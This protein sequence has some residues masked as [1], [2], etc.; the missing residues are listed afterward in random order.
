MAQ[1]QLQ[2]GLSLPLGSQGVAALPQLP[3]VFE[4]LELPGNALD[5][6]AA[7][8]SYLKREDFPACDFRDLIAARLSREITGESRAIVTEYKDQLRRMLKQAGEF[9]AQA[10]G[11]DPDWEKLCADPAATAVWN[12]ILRATAGDRMAAGIRLR[13]PVRVPGTAGRAAREAADWLLRLAGSQLSL[14]L[15]V[16]PHELLRQQTDWFDMLAP[17]RFAVDAV[18]FCYESELGNQLLY[19]HIQPFLAALRRW[20]REIIVYLAPSGRADLE[21]LAEVVQAAEK[22]SL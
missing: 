19:V 12:D 8:K 20:R 3:D 15:D 10:V 17:F 14:V 11:L 4:I 13:I 9:G 2:F 7:L 22:E 16:N 6:P 1:G 21:A 18:R 5:E